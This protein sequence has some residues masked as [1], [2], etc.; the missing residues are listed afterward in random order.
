VLQPAARAAEGAGLFFR[1]FVLEC[2]EKQF[3]HAWPSASVD[4]RAAF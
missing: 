4:L 1:N 3:A 2:V